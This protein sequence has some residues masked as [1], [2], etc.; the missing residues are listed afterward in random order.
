MMGGQTVRAR[1]ALLPTGHARDLIDGYRVSCIDQ[2]T[3]MLLVDC[4]GRNPDLNALLQVRRQVG[5][6][7][8]LGDVRTLNSPRLVMVLGLEE[9]G[10]AAPLCRLAGIADRPDP[11]MEGVGGEEAGAVGDSANV[12]ESII[13][14]WIARNA[15]AAECLRI[16]S[17]PDDLEYRVSL[18]GPRSG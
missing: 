2:G 3:P 5:Y 13:G 9:A 15:P 17:V 8:G 14:I 12:R 11:V 16:R 6:L 18:A 1:R 10:S 4:R 7:M